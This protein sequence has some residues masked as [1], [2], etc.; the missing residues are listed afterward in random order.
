M[1]MPTFF[2]LLL[3]KI[4]SPALV[5]LFHNNP[6]SFTIH[7]HDIVERLGEDYSTYVDFI[8]QK[9]RTKIKRNV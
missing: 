8:L 9:F 5:N 2:A 4:T 3:H 1:A 7:K 6:L